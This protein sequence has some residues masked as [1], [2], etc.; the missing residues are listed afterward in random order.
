MAGF[1]TRY[2]EAQRQGSRKPA[3]Q[4]KATTNEFAV[5]NASQKELVRKRIIEG[6]ELPFGKEVGGRYRES[7][8]ED[9]LRSEDNV[10]LKY[11]VSLVPRRGRARA[12]WD[13]ATLAVQ[14]REKVLT[15]D[16]PYIELNKDFI[17]ALR[18][19]CDGVFPTPE[20]CIYSLQVHV[21]D[22]RIP[23]LPHIVV[24]DRLENGQFVRPHFIWLLPYGSA[25]WHSKDERCR[26]EPIRLFDAV[27]RGLAAALLDIGAD[28]AAPTMTMRMKCPTSPIWHTITPNADVWPTL[29]EYADR[30]DTGV[31]RPVLARRAA[32]VQSGLGLTASNAIFDALR[33]EGQRTLAEWHF[34]TDK[35]MRGTREALADHLHEA[36]TAFAE[37]SELS[38]TQ[39]G[40]VTG[41][42]ADYLAANFDP[43]KLEN[44]SVNRGRLL[45]VVDGMT[46]VAD[47]QAAGGRHAAKSNADR[48]ISKL[49]DAY[50]SLSADGVDV[51]K[52]ALAKAAHVSRRTVINRWNDLV[53]ALEQGC[54]KQC[55][56]KKVPAISH[57]D[58]TDHGT[59]PRT[60]YLILMDDS[61]EDSTALACHEAWIALEEG[62]VPR[63][64]ILNAVSA[65]VGPAPPVSGRFAGTPAADVDS[66]TACANSRVI[67]G[68]GER[69]ACHSDMLISRSDA[70]RAFG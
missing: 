63:P 27:C 56:D 53:K 46:S 19:D 70:L 65:S 67:P 66:Q 48:T 45:D 62:R 18:V 44:P 59:A 43:S 22:G 36:L 50:R 9:G 3:R 41:K 10:V 34:G 47:R 30:V 54:E 33:T 39:V 23:C 69:Y 26:Q 49:V 28:P 14:C 12:S 38:D 1:E 6:Y 55:I 51:T 37:K 13:K 68:T 32:A 58:K 25:V 29:S 8:R 35:R 42:V 60:G 11:F 5:Q 24:G 4:T 16:Y 31:S 57:T 7:F 17:A 40:Y 20:A 61:D 64:E 2:A 52:S 21:R 15:L